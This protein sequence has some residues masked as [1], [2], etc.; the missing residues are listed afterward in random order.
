MSFQNRRLT[1]SVLVE[2][3]NVKRWRNLPGTD[4]DSGPGVYVVGRVKSVFWDVYVYV[5]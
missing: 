4:V 1:I 2:L 3:S 5:L